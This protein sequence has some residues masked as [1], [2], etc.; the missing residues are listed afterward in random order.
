MRDQVF[1]PKTTYI[2]RVRHRIMEGDCQ[3][4]H[5]PRVV[6]V[7]PLYADKYPVTNAQYYQFVLDSGYLPQDT[8]GY[9]KHWKD[10][11]YLPEDADCPVVNVS[12]KDAMAYASFYGCRLPL[13]YEWQLMAAGPGKKTYP[14][15]N[16][17][18]FSYCSAEKEKPSP[19]NIHPEGASEYGCE[20]MCGNTMEWTGDLIDDGMH[21]FT[22]LRG[23]SFYKA[24]HF[25]HAEGGC[26]RNDFHLKFPLLNEAMNRCETVGFRCVREVE[27]DNQK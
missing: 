20:D 23:G 3:Y 10:G 13:D 7:G 12:P 24:P 18:D 8:S 16:T 22:F 5:G 2:Y 4:D 1:I 19:V 11:K 27:N 15:G 14:W 17:F 25:W 9:L 6:T 26:H 21:L